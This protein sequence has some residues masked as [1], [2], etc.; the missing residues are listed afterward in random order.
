MFKQMLE[1]IFDTDVYKEFMGKS[2]PENVYVSDRDK[3][4]IDALLARPSA[5]PYDDEGTY[6]CW[7]LRISL[8][9]KIT[10]T[11]KNPED[12][13]NRKLSNSQFIDYISNT[14]YNAMYGTWT[15]EEDGINRVRFHRT[16]FGIGG[17]NVTEEIIV[18]INLRSDL[19]KAINKVRKSKSLLARFGF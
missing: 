11:H 7:L 17:K 4:R 10:I 2:E 14:E 1:S 19:K 16:F 8:W 6:E 12:R 9:G 5:V 3:A 15:V 13:T 18:D